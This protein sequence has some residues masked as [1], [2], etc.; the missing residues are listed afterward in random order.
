MENKE[1]NQSIAKLI[2]EFFY[3]FLYIFNE[4]QN[5]VYIK[6]QEGF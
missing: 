2:A 3:Y 5:E 1:K 6:N 4:T